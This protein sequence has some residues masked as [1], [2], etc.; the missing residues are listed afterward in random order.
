M[1]RLEHHDKPTRHL[2]EFEE[3]GHSQE[4][5]GSE[6]HMGSLLMWQSR[7]S[8]RTQKTEEPTIDSMELENNSENS[9]GLATELSKGRTHSHSVESILGF[10]DRTRCA[11]CHQP[12]PKRRFHYGGITCLLFYPMCLEREEGNFL[13]C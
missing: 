4:A 9:F 10:D 2:K 1:D 12:M 3:S 6:L 7:E 11:V 8:S 13:I 5:S